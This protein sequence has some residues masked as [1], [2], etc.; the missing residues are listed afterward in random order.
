MLLYVLL[1]YLNYEKTEQ[2]FFLLLNFFWTSDW[3]YVNMYVKPPAGKEES[4]AWESPPHPINQTYPFTLAC[5]VPSL[6]HHEPPSFSSWGLDNDFVLFMIHE[7]VHR[8]LKVL[9][10]SSE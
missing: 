10:F 4:S 7:E 8:G 6:Y 3:V 1:A 2:T 5:Q 9:A